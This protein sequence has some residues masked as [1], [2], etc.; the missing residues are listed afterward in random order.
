MSKIIT[1]VSEWEAAGGLD[2]NLMRPVSNQ[3]NV[4]FNT[5]ALLRIDEWRDIDAAVRDVAREKLIG[6]QDIV[7]GGMIHRLGGLGSTVTTYEQLSD[8]T[9]AEIDMAGI[10]RGDGDAVAFTPVNIPV[11]IIHKDF[12]I[13]KRKLEASR[14]MGEALDTTQVRTAARKVRDAMEAL[15]F[16]G[17]GA[18]VQDGSTIYGY[19]N[20]PQRLTDSAT[21]YGGGDFGTEGNGYAS[22]AGGIAALE[23]IFFYGSY[24]VYIAGTQFGELRNRHTDGSGTS[25]LKA[26]KA[27]IPEIRDIKRS[28]QLAAGEVVIIQF[29]AETVDLAIGQD[30]ITVQWSVE[31][32]MQARY[33]VMTALAPRIKHDAN[34]ALGVL[35]MTGA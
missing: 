30:L 29:D 24:Q 35:H 22:I 7:D 14:R 23:A 9:P 17:T 4:Q 12:V 33:K 32:G 1:N 6:I 18:P 27:G 8:M 21:N 10:T 20:H 13:N 28:D 3:K 34:N 11:P 5:N 25:E 2:P 15:L 26:I 31:G 16:N 19:T